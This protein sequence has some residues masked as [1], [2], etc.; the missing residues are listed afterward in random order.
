MAAYNYKCS[1]QHLGH[2]LIK[3]E[4]LLA[5]KNTAVK[6]VFSVCRGFCYDCPFQYTNT[7][8]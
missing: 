8:G 3:L 2:I 7:S 1:P 4:I 5:D 6:D